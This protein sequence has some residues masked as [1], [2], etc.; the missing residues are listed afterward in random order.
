MIINELNAQPN[1]FIVGH[2]KFST[3]TK[4]EY[5]RVRGR[6]QGVNATGKVV[7]LDSS[8]LANEV[9]WRTKGAVNPV[10]DQMMCGSCWAFSSIA[11]MEG[12]HAIQKG[13]LVKLSEQ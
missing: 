6:Q 7:S 5:K 12:S 8:V 10:Q 9:D 1:S 4:D 11:A 2:N 13:E 3:F